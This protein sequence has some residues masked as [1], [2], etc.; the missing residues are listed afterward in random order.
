MKLE[1][2]FGLISNASGGTSK[3]IWVLKKAESFID[4]LPQFLV[5]TLPAIFSATSF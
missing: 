1:L 2:T 4:N 3:S 5:A